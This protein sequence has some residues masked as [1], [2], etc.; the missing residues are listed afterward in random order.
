M[1]LYELIIIDFFLSLKRTIKGKT[2]FIPWPDNLRGYE[3]NAIITNPLSNGEHQPSFPMFV[4]DWKRTYMA[5]SISKQ[6]ERMRNEGDWWRAVGKGAL[7]IYVSKIPNFLHF[8]EK[9][10][11]RQIERGYP[12]QTT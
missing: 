6:A 10:E 5:K 3:E 7:E 4:S 11:S 8:A 2:L 12:D 1:C 9:R